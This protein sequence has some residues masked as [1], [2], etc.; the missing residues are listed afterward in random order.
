MNSFN[1]HINLY[2]LAALGAIFIALAFAVLLGF[3]KNSYNTANRFLALALVCVVLIMIG[4]L[5][6]EPELAGRFQHLTCLLAPFSLAVAP[7]VYFYVLKV[8]RPGYKLGYR[9]LLHFSPLLLSAILAFCISESLHNL[10]SLLQASAFVSITA[11]LYYAHKLIPRFQQSPGSKLTDRHRHELWRLRRLM[12]R[13]VILWLLTALFIVAT[14]FDQDK[15][16]GIYFYYSPYL[17]LAVITIRLG[18]IAFSWPAVNVPVPQSAVHKPTPSSELAQKG[19]WLKNA[20]KSGQFHLDAELSLSSLAERLDTNPHELSRIINGA[21]KKNFNDFVNEYR[22]RDVVLK[23]QD[24]AYDRITL[25]GIAFE[26]GFNA[27]S[28]FN[29]IF[30]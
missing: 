9:D 5:G 26:S 12:K 21:L 28:T 20:M 10:T 17:V 2:G 16:E 13:F 23:M 14:F 7:L 8:A 18:A 27:Q 15:A 19:A 30:K 4:V 6:R 24:P 22:V 29:R 11:Y 3:T 25:L 1:L